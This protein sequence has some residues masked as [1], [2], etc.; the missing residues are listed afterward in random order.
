M[1]TLLYNVNSQDVQNMKDL[2]FEVLN[3]Q[4]IISETNIIMNPADGNVSINKDENVGVQK[5]YALDVAAKLDDVDPNFEN[6]ICISRAQPL[7]AVQVVGWRINNSNPTEPTFQQVDIVND[8]V[9]SSYNIGPLNQ[10]LTTFF[11][12]VYI[13]GDLESAILRINQIIPNVNNYITVNGGIAIEKS[14]S[15]QL[16]TPTFTTTTS[17]GVLRVNTLSIPANTSVTLTLNNNN[18]L[19]DSVVLFTLVSAAPQR[20]FLNLITTAVAL[21]SVSAQIFNNDPVINY[22]TVLEINYLIM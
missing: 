9:I 6:G 15:I 5:K 20:K 1:D 18:I 11:N 12:D 22:N 2:G 14:N 17:C 13:M 19:A 7:E 16:T 3:V 4:Q 21:G 8:V 10:S